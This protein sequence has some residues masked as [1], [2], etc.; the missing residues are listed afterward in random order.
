MSICYGVHLA[1]AASARNWGR[2]L[3]SDAAILPMIPIQLHLWQQ[4]SL[5]PRRA[6][7]LPF[8]N[9][10]QLGFSGTAL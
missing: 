4:L 6:I 10:P 5:H 7:D 2:F 1:T 3:H 8:L 9:T